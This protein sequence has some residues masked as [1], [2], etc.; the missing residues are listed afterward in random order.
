MVWLFKSSDV[1]DL[2]DLRQAM[3]CIEE[4]CREQAS[5][6]VVA[7]PPSLMH[8][9][10]G[11][12]ILRS[13]GLPARGKMG[14]RV[15]TGP[16]NVS[17]AL[18]FET[19][20]G[21]L[22]SMI[23]YPFSELRVCATVA[24]GLD[25]LAQPDARRVASIGTG[26]SALG[27]LEAAAAVRSIQSVKAYSRGPGRRAAF[28]ARAQRTLGVPVVATDTPEQAVRDA[29]LVLVATNSE[30][31]AVWGKWLEPGTH[32]TAMGVRTELDEE[33]F[34]RAERIVTTSRVQEMNIHDI[35]DDWP[36]VRLIRSG[37]LKWDDV[38]ELGDVI[39]RGEPPPV[40]ITVFREAQGGFGDVA[41]AAWAYERARALGRG[42][43]VD[44]D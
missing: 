12:L 25:R 3:A 18:V 36:L 15:T 29:Q 6:E 30:T 28:A 10:G 21:R 4:V 5:G 41:L 2:V 40:G 44:L 42:I 43:E 35:R 9:G 17:W 37:E 38:L 14:V 22:Q 26:R 7:W 13:G 32:V 1:E 34:R 39:A 20:S 27:L 31:P 33:V 8:S 19:P 11:L 24:L 23:A 16:H